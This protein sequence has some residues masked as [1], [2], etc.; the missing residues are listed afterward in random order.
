MRLAFDVRLNFG[1]DQ[2]NFW[3]LNVIILNSKA[4]WYNLRGV[5]K[6][7]NFVLKVHQMKFLRHS[8]QNCRRLIVL[9]LFFAFLQQKCSTFRILVC[10]TCKTYS[11]NVPAKSNTIVMTFK[12]RLCKLSQHEYP[13]QNTKTNTG[14]PQSLR[15][16]RTAS[17]VN[18][19]EAVI[20]EDWGP[21]NEDR[22]LRTK[23]RGLR[24]ED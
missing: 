19:Y 18:G 9:R 15:S 5:L 22:G 23:D 10:H 8:R 1:P 2:L 20:T 11:L 12:V 16:L 6:S 24:I 17:Q 21:R 4:G 13:P 3:K 7:L 14:H